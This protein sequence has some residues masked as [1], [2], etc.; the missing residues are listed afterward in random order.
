MRK[1]PSYYREIQ[2]QQFGHWTVLERRP[3]RRTKAYYLCRCS[4]GLKREVAKAELESGRSTNCG[5]VNKPNLQPRLEGYLKRWSKEEEQ[6]LRTLYPIRGSAYVASIL[7]RSQV[8]VIAKA[9]KLGVK[10]ELE[11]QYLNREGRWKSWEIAALEKYYPE[12]GVAACRPHLPSRSKNAIWN[13][14]TKMKLKVKH[15]TRYRNKDYKGNDK[16]TQ[17]V[18]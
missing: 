3:N 17:R 5:H 14:A 2:G 15:V 4:C 9:N 7:R 1:P 8:A 6:L 18:A 13:K 16:R 11:V 12:G 10:C